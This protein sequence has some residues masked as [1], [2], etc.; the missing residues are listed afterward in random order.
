MEYTVIGDVVNVAFR[1]ERLNKEFGSKL[2]ISERVRQRA[3]PA[4]RWRVHS[5]HRD[6][7]PK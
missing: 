7:R 2:L 4:R 3:G 6:S 5:T 1:I